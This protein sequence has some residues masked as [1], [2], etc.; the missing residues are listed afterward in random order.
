MDQANPVPPLQHIFV[1]YSRADS[2]TVDRIVSRLETDGFDVWL[3]REDI[4]GGD[5][6]SQQIVKAVGNAYA[7]LLMLSPS[8]AASKNVRQEV[9]LAF[10]GDKDFVP[11]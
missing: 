2:G 5:I 11:L 10:G 6:W 8:A 1:S 3:D 9:Y 7:F 4:M